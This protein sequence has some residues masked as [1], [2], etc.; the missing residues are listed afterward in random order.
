MSEETVGSSDFTYRDD[1]GAEV[2]PSDP[3]HHRAMFYGGSVPPKTELKEVVL[4]PPAFGS[5]DPRTLGHVMLPAGNEQTD[6]AP[7]ISEDYA[8]GKPLFNKVSSSH[9]EDSTQGGGSDSND[10]N[11]QSDRDWNK[12]MRK[13]EL[14]KVAEARGLDV[15]EENTVPELHEALENDD[16]QREQADPDAHARQNQ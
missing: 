15:K 12:S 6:S 4:G 8:S 2:H 10:G 13:D 11:S 9:E 1:L 7:E 3:D 16:K 14:L 5:P